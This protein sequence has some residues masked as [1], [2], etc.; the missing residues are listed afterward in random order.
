M[1]WWNIGMMRGRHRLWV[2]ASY[3]CNPF[4]QHPGLLGGEEVQT[5]VKSVADRA[6]LLGALRLLATS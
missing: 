1:E 2:Y 6:A 5:L 4:T 3:C